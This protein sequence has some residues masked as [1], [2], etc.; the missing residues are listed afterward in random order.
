MLDASPADFFLDGEDRFEIAVRDACADDEFECRKDTCDS[1]FII[2]SKAVPTVGP[3]IPGTMQNGLA[4]WT[5]SRVDAI[6]MCGEQQ[7]RGKVSGR[8]YCADQ[9]PHRIPCRFESE[10]VETV[11]QVIGNG[12][13]VPG[14]AVYASEI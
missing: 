13:L 14:G 7:V 9:V 3:D 1:R 10:L 8:S 11:L 4:G 5:V 2:C 12:R 6:H